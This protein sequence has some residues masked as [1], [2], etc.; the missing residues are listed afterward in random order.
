MRTVVL[1]SHKTV[2][3]MSAS[4]TMYIPTF[5]TVYLIVGP[6]PVSVTIMFPSDSSSKV[7]CREK[8]KESRKHRKTIIE[9][10]DRHQLGFHPKIQIKLVCKTGISHK[11]F[12]NKAQFP[13]NESKRT[14]SSLPWKTVPLNITKNIGEDTE[15]KNCNILHN[16]L[17]PQSEQTRHKKCYYYFRRRMLLFANSHVRQ[18]YRNTLTTDFAQA[19]QNDQNN[20]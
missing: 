9:S 19:F 4:M 1:R 18:L 11:T 13:S 14:K 12:A 20:I 6:L 17:A 5:L 7:L 16:L 10:S 15:Y 8:E 3:P 2:R